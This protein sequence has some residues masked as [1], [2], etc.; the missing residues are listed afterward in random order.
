MIIEIPN[1]D[2]KTFIDLTKLYFNKEKL[3]YT[4]MEL[5]YTKKIGHKPNIKHLYKYPNPNYKTMDF[6]EYCRLSLDKLM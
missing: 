6:K 1:T 5:E 4:T 2:N 3:D